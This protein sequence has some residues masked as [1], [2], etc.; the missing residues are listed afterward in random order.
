MDA[1]QDK[2]LAYA[3]PQ[4]RRFSKL[5]LTAFVIGFLGLPLFFGQVYLGDDMEHKLGM[6]PVTVTWGLFILMPLTGFVLG[7]IA[8][9]RIVESNGKLRGLVFAALGI[10][11]SVIW[12]IALFTVIWSAFSRGIH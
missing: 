1:E 5:A 12:P 7:I 10:L 9:A 2:I 3:T 6:D 11:L 4:E 8:M